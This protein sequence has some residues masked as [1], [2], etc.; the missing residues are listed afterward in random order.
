MRLVA[1]AEGDNTTL[2]QQLA[3]LRSAHAADA[4][5]HEERMLEEQRKHLRAV[6]EERRVEVRQFGARA[7]RKVSSLLEKAACRFVAAMSPVE[8]LL[9]LVEEDGWG[10]DGGVWGRGDGG[11]GGG[12]GGLGSPNSLGE[13]DESVLGEVIRMLD[14]S[15]LT[16]KQGSG[17]V[18]EASKQRKGA[19]LGHGGKASARFR[20]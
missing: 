10:G 8:D 1:T 19:A 17:G 6:L 13:E 20:V 4:R 11:G 16:L 18:F 9:V 12:G 5:G 15:A 7:M 2:T 3:A 14:D